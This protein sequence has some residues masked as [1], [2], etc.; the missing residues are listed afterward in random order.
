MD[1]ATRTAWSI[2][3][4]SF[5]ELGTAYSMAKSLLEK[6]TSA[7]RTAVIT[8][9]CQT[10]FKTL[11]DTMR[12]FKRRFFL[13]PP[14]QDPTDYIR[15]GLSPPDK[16]PTRTGKP[17]AQ[18]TVETRLHGRHELGIEII[19]LTGSPDDKANKSYRIWYKVVS[20]DETPP[21]SPD[22]LPKSFSTKRKKDVINFDFGDSGK[23]AYI[24][25]QV[26]NDNK[27]GDW[28]PMVN[29]VIP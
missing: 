13:S 26:E 12:S 27:K 4:D 23:M 10:A 25:V 6:A 19:Y 17:T 15:L 14:L 28:G 21:V 11:A 18:V 1:A 16:I 3:T 5:T 24:A 8:A 29:A 2:P 20:H 22:D 7:E 9:E